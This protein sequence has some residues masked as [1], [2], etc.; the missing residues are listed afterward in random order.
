[1]D[2][3]TLRYIAA[4]TGIVVVIGITTYVAGPEIA[5]FL[6]P[7]V[8]APFAWF[9]ASAVITALSHYFR[10]GTFVEACIDA[11]I[12][13]GVLLAATLLFTTFLL[14]FHEQAWSYEIELDLLWDLVAWLFGEASII[15]L[16][17]LFK[18]ESS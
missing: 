13:A 7:V 18:R 10:N 12:I 17:K 1:M 11:S 3:T 6:R 8:S 15:G 2:K 4:L 9:F 14:I 5:V 16:E